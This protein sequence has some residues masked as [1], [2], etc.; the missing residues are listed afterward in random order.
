MI[1]ARRGGESR[2][3]AEAIR[4]RKDREAIPSVETFVPARHRS[5][6]NAGS[7]FFLDSLELISRTLDAREGGGNRFLMHEIEMCLRS[8]IQRREVCLDE[9]RVL[10]RVGDPAE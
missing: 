4:I 5:Y 6:R 2:L 3:S 7:K 10:Y 8:A 1:G 9:V